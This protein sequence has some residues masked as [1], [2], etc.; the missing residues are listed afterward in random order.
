MLPYE[1]ELS[2]HHKP[3]VKYSCKHSAQPG[4]PN[5]N[6]WHCIEGYQAA[7]LAA[8]ASQSLTHHYLSNVTN[9]TLKIMYIRRLLISDCPNISTIFPAITYRIVWWS[10]CSSTDWLLYTT[11]LLFDLLQRV[12]QCEVMPAMTKLWEANECY[13]DSV[14]TI[15]LYKLSPHRVTGWSLLVKLDENDCLVNSPFYMDGVPSCFLNTFYVW[16]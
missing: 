12:L 16:E 8:G 1:T 5:T 13:I 15:K 11:L 14:G 10:S 3:S 2:L 7:S 4:S 6:T 9:F